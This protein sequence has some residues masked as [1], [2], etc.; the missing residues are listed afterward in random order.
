[1][2]I[3]PRGDWT[4]ILTMRLECCA[5]WAHD[6]TRSGGHAAKKDSL[7]ACLQD[8]PDDANR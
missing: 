8:G 6:L 1:M 3:K 7:R 5:F 2:V 4:T